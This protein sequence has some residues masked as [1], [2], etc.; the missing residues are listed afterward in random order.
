[1]CIVIC[2]KACS[3]HKYTKVCSFCKLHTYFIFWVGRVAAWL[4]CY[5]NSDQH[6][7]CAFA[8]IMQYCAILERDISNVDDILNIYH[9]VQF[10][11][12]PI[13]LQTTCNSSY[14]HPY[15]TLLNLNHTAIIE[16]ESPVEWY[17]KKIIYSGLLVIMYVAD[18]LLHIKAWIRNH[19]A[20]S[21]W[22]WICH[23]Y[24]NR[25]GCGSKPFLK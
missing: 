4:F 8:M 14:A 10:K 12:L 6:C 5:L 9:G 25:N 15:C 16:F 24:R 21:A 22:D 2:T 7:I 17:V 20:G 23:I 19:I 18:S 1:M 13:Q 11:V 3:L